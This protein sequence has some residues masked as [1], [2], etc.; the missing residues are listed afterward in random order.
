MNNNIHSLPLLLSLLQL[1]I[2]A[3]SLS[4]GKVKAE[5]AQCLFHVAAR[6]LAQRCSSVPGMALIVS[7]HLGSCVR[8][9]GQGEMG[10]CTLFMYVY[11]RL[12]ALA[13][14]W[15]NINISMNKRVRDPE[16]VRVCVLVRVRVCIHLCAHALIYE[17]VHVYN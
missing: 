12:C 2:T 8:G 14:I 3:V 16:R 4:E 1:I 9:M 6:H 17:I 15:M 7:E 5:G 10:K 11:I 13:W